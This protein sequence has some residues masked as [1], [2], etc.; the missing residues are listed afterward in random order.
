MRRGRS[1]VCYQRNEGRM[2]FGYINIYW[3]KP[4]NQHQ[5]QHKNINK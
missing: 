1:R 5:H 4:R 2:M 3:M